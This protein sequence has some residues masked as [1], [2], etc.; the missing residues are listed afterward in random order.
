MPLNGKIALVDYNKCS[1]AGCEGGV[2]AAS[3][4]CKRKLLVQE[5]P[6][7]IP[8]T[9]LFSCRACGDCARAC[10]VNAIQLTPA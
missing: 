3:E 7:D 10:P 4:A 5:K 2:C 8:M 6:Y 1:P 9:S